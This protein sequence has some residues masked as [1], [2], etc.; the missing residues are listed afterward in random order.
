VYIGL[1]GLIIIGVAAIAV[2]LIRKGI[3]LFIGHS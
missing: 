1:T 3:L 2:M